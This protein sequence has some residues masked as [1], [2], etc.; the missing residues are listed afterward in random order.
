VECSL[1]IDEVIKNIESVFKRFNDFRQGCKWA[2]TDDYDIN[3]RENNDCE[4]SRR[5]SFGNYAKSKK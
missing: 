4:E 3:N 5:K 2:I 1:G